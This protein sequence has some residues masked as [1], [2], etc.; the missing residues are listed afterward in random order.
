MVIEFSPAGQLISL[1]THHHSCSS[2]THNFT[3]QAHIYTLGTMAA[4]FAPPP[5]PSIVA[6][7]NVWVVGEK[8]GATASV[9]TCACAV[10][11]CTCG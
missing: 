1:V 11:V 4:H 5:M 10:Y 7:S 6:P 3:S 9:C 8:A 2:L